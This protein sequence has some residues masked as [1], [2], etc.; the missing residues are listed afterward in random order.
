MAP[1]REDRA[2]AAA[3]RTARDQA[4]ALRCDQCE[5]SAR[6]EIQQPREQQRI[7]DA[8]EQLCKGGARAK[9]ECRAEREY[10]SAEGAVGIRLAIHG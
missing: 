5:A 9:Q 2:R 8:E 4:N 6:A 1:A 10:R 3:P 7:G